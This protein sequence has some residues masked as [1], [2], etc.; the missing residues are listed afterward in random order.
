PGLRAPVSA[1]VSGGRSRRGTGPGRA[2][3]TAAA[4][5]RP[6]SRRHGSG[7]GRAARRPV[8]RRGSRAGSVDV[9]GRPIPRGHGARYVRRAADAV[10]IARAVYSDFHLVARVI[11]VRTGVLVVLADAEDLTPA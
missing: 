2:T 7:A 9:V 6:P 8:A 11:V 3:H 10:G 5:P 4:P 1:T